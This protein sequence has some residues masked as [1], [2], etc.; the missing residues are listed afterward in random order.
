VALRGTQ[1][2]RDPWL[3]EAKRQRGAEVG[4]GRWG[5]GGGERETETE[6]ETEDEDGDKAR[7]RT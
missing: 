6:T 3:H 5:A 4:G 2:G 1:A 7:A